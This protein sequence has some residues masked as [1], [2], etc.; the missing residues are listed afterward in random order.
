M[1]FCIFTLVFTYIVSELHRESP[2]HLGWCCDGEWCLAQGRSPLLH[3][4]SILLSFQNSCSIP[5][6]PRL[7]KTHFTAKCSLSLQVILKTVFT[8]LY[9]KTNQKKYK[10][11]F[12]STICHLSN[13]PKERTAINRRGF[14]KLQYKNVIPVIAH[15]A[16][17][18]LCRPAQP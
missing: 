9:I 11:I 13:G 2:P 10:T 12:F 17:T 5:S 6:T 1:C 7:R 8:F 18:C 3:Y 15:E 14:Y 16:C 4:A